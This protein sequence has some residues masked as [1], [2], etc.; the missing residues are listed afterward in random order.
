MTHEQLH[1][2]APIKRVRPLPP[3]EGS[4]KP[5]LGPCR[6]Q[7]CG[8][9]LWWATANSRWMGVTVRRTHWRDVDGTMHRC[10]GMG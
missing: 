1:A 2:P 5:K 4:E 8:E 9:P 3:Y 6:C 10:E 7:G